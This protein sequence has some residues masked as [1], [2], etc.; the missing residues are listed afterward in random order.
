M[1]MDFAL[2]LLLSWLGVAGYLQYSFLNILCGKLI[3]IFVTICS[4]LQFED[5]VWDA[6]NVYGSAIEGDSLTTGTPL[7]C[8]PLIDMISNDPILRGVKVLSLDFS[9]TLLAGH[10]VLIWLI[11]GFEQRTFW[12]PH[13]HFIKLFEYH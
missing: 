5:S 11:V 2:I 3:I 7:S 4:F 9:F 13:N 10:S 1:S 8:P 12:F 6:V